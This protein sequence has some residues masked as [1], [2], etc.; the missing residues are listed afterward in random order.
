[1]PKTIPDNALTTALRAIENNSSLNRLLKDL[2]RYQAIFRAAEGPLAELRRAGVFDALSPYRQEL[3]RTQKL[4]QQFD[5][6]F[7][8]PEIHEAARLMAEYQKSPL[9]EVLHRYQQQTRSLQQA[10]ER[11]QRPWLDI[12]DRLQSVNSF[13]KLH[14][15]GQAVV[16][17]PTFEP[18]LTSALR[19]DLGDWRE[20]ITFSNKVLVDLHKRSELY[21]ELGFDPTLTEFPSPAFHETL[22][23]AGVV[24]KPPSLVAMYESPVPPSDDE[25]E[26]VQLE[27]TNMAQG[28]LLRLETQIRQFIDER[29]TEAFG[30]SWPKHRLPKSLYDKWR[31][32]KARAKRAGAREWPL[33]A[34]ADFTDYVAVI[35]KRDNW[36][37]VFVSY[38][39]R[40]EYVRESFQRL[41]PV[42]LDT[43]HAR[44]ITQDDELLLYVETQRLVKV[45]LSTPQRRTID[46]E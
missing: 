25:A 21:Q 31:E 33:I 1:V 27:R 3:Q 4:L 9:A 24:R 22:D 19:S 35:C 14:S 40:P 43:M 34:Y 13:I 6:K 8:L 30:P 42:S 20:R 44:P 15:I 37:E 18:S 7:C 12:Q 32:K 26:E 46:G 10:M 45:V 17:T 41:Y 16:T 29:M 39:N 2:N 5:A 36:R 23:I 11:M 38:F 28:W